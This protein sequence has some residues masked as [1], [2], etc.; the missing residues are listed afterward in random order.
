MGKIYRQPSELSSNY[1]FIVVGAGNAGAVVAARLAENP[2]FKVLVIEAGLSDN[3][4]G[5]DVLRM[6]FLAGRASGTKFDWNYKTTAQEG[7][8]SRVVEFPRGFV[9]GGCSNINNLVYI[10]GPKNDFDRLA[11]VSGDP[12]WSWSALDKYAKMNES[13]VQAWNGNDGEYDPTAHGHGPLKTSLVAEPSELDQR[14][15]EASKQLKN[16]FPWKHDLNS[17]DCLGLGWIH[18]TVGDGQRSSSSTAFLNPALEARDNIDLLLSTHVTRLAPTEVGGVDF[19]VVETAQ[20]ANGISTKITAK[21]EVILCA[22]AIGTPQIL[23]LSGIGPKAVL[24][25]AGVAQLVD[26]PDVG[27]HLQDQPFIFYQWR[28]NAPTLA[29]HLRDPANL[30]SA[31]AEYAKS[32]TGFAAGAARYNT[33][34][35][36]RLQEAEMTRLLEGARDPAAGP[37]SAHFLWMFVNT[38]VP[39]PGQSPPTEGDWISV[40]AVLQS[41]TSSGSVDIVSYSAFDHPAINPAFLSTAFD[42]GTMISAFKTIHKF[43]SAP[44]WTGFFGEPSDEVA[45]LINDAAIEAYIRKYATTIRHPVSTARISRAD[46]D[47]GV[48]GPDLK[49][50][51]VQGLRVVDGSVLPFASAG[52]P[53]AQIYILAERA[54]AL[55]KETWA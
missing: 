28:A 7:L 1:D 22:G 24:D 21:K 29:S 45:A 41:P 51:K 39:N 40:S 46:E 2:A 35:F 5:S 49:V 8:G 25:R 53:Q 30:S 52:F 23:Q 50:K 16:E 12:G 55:I 38:F 34:A 9:V 27:Q 36:L 43:F 6:P 26:L 47:A 18:T 3:E 13:H 54:A 17:G 48:V 15:K 31:M 14:V 4:E 11:E 42:I 37:D 32:K 20:T 19:R 33:I 44:A 10:R